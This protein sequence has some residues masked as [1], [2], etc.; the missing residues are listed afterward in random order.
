MW[1]LG[2]HG[3]T[4]RGDPFAGSGVTSGQISALMVDF[5]GDKRIAAIFMHEFV[6]IV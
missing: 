2:R 4:A 5:T 3:T 6:T 1:R